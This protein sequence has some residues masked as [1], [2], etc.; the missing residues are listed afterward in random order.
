MVTTWQ[1]KQRGNFMQQRPGCL[2]GLF[3]LFALNWV[4]QWLQKNFGFGRGSC[5]GA[6]CGIILLVIFVLIA[7]SILAGTDWLQI[8]F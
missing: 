6:G 2:S 8:G 5:G 7:C 4:F 1:T 3:K